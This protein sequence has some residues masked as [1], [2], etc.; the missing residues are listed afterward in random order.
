MKQI[1]DLILPAVMVLI[2][3]YGMWKKIPVFDCFLDGAREGL[4][5]AVQI[6]PALIALITAVGMLKASGMLDFLIAFVSPLFSLMQMPAQVIPLALLRPISGSG[7]LVIYRDILQ[8]AGPDSFVGRV[9]SVMQGSTETTF[10]T[11]AVYYGSTK[12]T[13]TRHTLPAALTADMIGFLMSAV[14]VRLLLGK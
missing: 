6:L 11:I 10:Y 8:Q 2:I 4:L 3:G 1:S 9:A 12:V 7:A 13:R 5:S 14:A